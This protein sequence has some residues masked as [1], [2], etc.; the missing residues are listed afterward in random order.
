[1][2]DRNKDLEQLEEKLRL[3][4][5]KVPEAKNKA[6]FKAEF[7][8]MV[9]EAA[10]AQAVLST[11]GSPGLMDLFRFKMAK[12]AAAITA[13]ATLLGGAAYASQSAL[14]NTPLYKVKRTIESAKLALPLSDESRVQI[15]INQLD[16]RL[17]E[18]SK[19]KNTG[20]G[21]QFLTQD[22]DA[23]VSRLQESFDKLP[24]HVQEQIA[25][26]I[27]KVIK[28]R[29]EQIKKID[30]K[31]KPDNKGFIDKV[32]IPVA[33]TGPTG[34]NGQTEQPVIDPA[35]QVPES[36]VAIV[37][38]TIGTLTPIP[39][40]STAPP[41]KL[42]EKI[43]GNSNSAA[44]VPDIFKPDVALKASIKALIKKQQNDLKFIAKILLP[45]PKEAGKNAKDYLKVFEPAVEERSTS[46]VMDKDPAVEEARPNITGSSKPREKCW[47][48]VL[49]DHEIAANA[50]DET[51][52]EFIQR[53]ETKPQRPPKRQR[54][55]KN[56]TRSLYR[57]P[58]NK[59]I[60]EV[61]EVSETQI[62]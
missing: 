4:G 53:I 20:K 22:I 62:Y 39:S 26:E 37:I 27:K 55:L 57:A 11:N 59:D 2:D 29:D 30:D 44:N 23:T 19:I 56:S 32:E 10:E 8:Q 5:A 50:N 41:V 13:M 35:P 1:M 49:E 60:K 18:L 17:N 9:D 48:P 52:K 61:A 36:T 46:N 40:T 43:P 12:F 31:I 14:P 38:P 45:V 6:S 21:E 58:D 28:K 16:E 42:K 25:K 33:P 24:E 7:L 54:D 15:T 51:I 34:Q 3:L 47:K